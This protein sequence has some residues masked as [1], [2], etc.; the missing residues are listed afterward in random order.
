MQ[1]H[2][3]VHVPDFIEKLNWS[4]KSSTTDVIST[5]TQKQKEKKE[6]RKKEGKERERER[7]RGTCRRQNSAKNVSLV[8][9]ETL[10]ML[11]KL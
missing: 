10:K 7:I 4:E 2:W 8:N 1:Q 6:K 11:N 5:I 9:R 3:S